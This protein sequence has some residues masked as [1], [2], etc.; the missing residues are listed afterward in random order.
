MSMVRRRG[1]PIGLP[2]KEELPKPA[3]FDILTRAVLPIALVAFAQ[4]QEQQVRFWALIVLAFLTAVI[5]FYHV[6]TRQIRNWA[7]ELH[8]RHL[9]KMTFPKF[10]RFV[11]RLGDLLDTNRDDTLEYVVRDRL[12]RNTPARLEELRMVPLQ[13]FNGI[14][15]DL[16]SRVENQKPSLDNLVQSVAECR[17]LINLYNRYCVDPVFE[18]F[19]KEL[20]ELLTE[21]AKSGLESFREKFVSFLED[22][23]E[24][25]KDLEES[26]RTVRLRTYSVARPKPL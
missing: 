3:A 14:W 25:A 1:V 21:E 15:F 9:V 10:R 7:N 23:D 16:N 26:L 5:G 24:F 19:P 17:N 8:D 13:L 11:H 18:R 4:Q 12:F 22:Y 20:R 2:Q 6:G